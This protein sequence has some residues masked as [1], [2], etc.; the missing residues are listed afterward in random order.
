MTDNRTAESRSALMARVR[1]RDTAP[2]I[3][4]RK[5]LH[6]LGYRFRL[7]RRDLPGTP[8]IVLPSRRRIIFVHGCF[9]HAHG[10]SIGKPPK[11][12]IAYW[13]RK[14]RQNRR[15]DMRNYRLLRKAGWGVL[16]IWQCEI[17]DVNQLSA[18]LSS[19]L[20]LAGKN[21][22]TKSRKQAKL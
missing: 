13:K 14:F 3:V 22:S 2:E 11:S 19:T 6:G 16:T 5:I 12:H 7:H 8:D 17:K 1:G 18:R 20:G 21:R 9:W 15:R 10:C 4:V